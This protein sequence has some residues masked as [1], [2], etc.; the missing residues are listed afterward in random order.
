MMPNVKI[1]RT[2]KAQL[3]PSAGMMGWAWLVLMAATLTRPMG[4]AA[5]WTYRG[6]E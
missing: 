3:L 1:Q 6:I 4:K 5:P 2:E